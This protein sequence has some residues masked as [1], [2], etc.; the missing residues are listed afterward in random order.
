MTVLG[1]LW[2]CFGGC[3]EQKVSA[4][5]PIGWRE[6]QHQWWCRE[7]AGARAAHD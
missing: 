1:T 2:D 4:D 7:C 6:I 5:P 3:G